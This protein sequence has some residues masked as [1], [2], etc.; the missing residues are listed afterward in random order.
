MAYGPSYKVDYRRKRKGL[1]NYKKRLKLLSS[2]KPRFVV[3]KSNNAVTCQIIAYDAKG[4]KT[5]VT[6]SS[7]MLKKYGYKGHTGNLPAA[8][9]AGFMCGLKAKKHNI[10]EAILDIGL[11]RST[12]G[13]KI[14]AALKGA[15]DAGIK[16]PHNA[17][18]IPEERRIKG[19]HIADYAKILKAKDPQ[20]YEK[21]FSEMLKNKMLPEHMVEHFEEVKKRISG[22]HS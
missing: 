1:T 16:I 13:S 11:Y 18:I 2:G 21:L 17:K 10:T 22:E 9:L 14:Y 7:L 8:Y 3:R 19:Y 12:K 5:I 6:S 20:K 15:V 4:D